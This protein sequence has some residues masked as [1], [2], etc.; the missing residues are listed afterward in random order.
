MNNSNPDGLLI[1]TS[2]ASSGINSTQVSFDSRSTPRPPSSSS[3]SGGVLASGYY[4]NQATNSFNNLMH[5]SGYISGSTAFYNQQHEYNEFNSIAQSANL[6]SKSGS[7]ASGQPGEA[8]Q[9]EKRDPSCLGSNQRGPGV[10]LKGKKVRKPRTIYSSMQLQVLNKRFQR[11]QYLALPERAELAASLGLTQTQVKIWFQNKRS[12]FKKNVKNSDGSGDGDDCSDDSFDETTDAET[13]GKHEDFYPGTEDKDKQILSDV[14]NSHVLHGSNSLHQ[15]DTGSAKTTTKRKNSRSND[16]DAKKL[17]DG[18]SKK[19][20]SGNDEIKGQ[21]IKVEHKGITENRFSNVYSK[22]LN[23]NSDEDIDSD[24][25]LSYS[26]NSNKSRTESPAQYSL[27]TIATATDGSNL[28]VANYQANSQLNPNSKLTVQSGYTHHSSS[29]PSSSSSSSSTSS[30]NSY[31]SNNKQHNTSIEANDEA[32]LR[33]LVNS[34]ANNKPLNQFSHHQHQQ[35]SNYQ[36]NPALA[37]NNY[38]LS[39]YNIGNHQGLNGSYQNQ[40]FN[41]LG[42]AYNQHYNHVQTGQYDASVGSMPANGLANSEAQAWMINSVQ[43][44]S[45]HHTAYSASMNST[46]AAFSNPLHNPLNTHHQMIINGMQ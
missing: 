32:I 5:N 36:F 3:S 45:Q 35:Q 13:G 29:L 24:N 10:K 16:C 2:A 43:G 27:N 42:L 14:G 46:S 39:N 30:I 8:S 31:T 22:I 18:G 20:K 11:T 40:S 44:A 12:K 4:N 26:T 19:F 9:H 41:N 28:P 25:S 17:S 21:K 6:L 38:Q 1:A 33:S 7:Y 23:S 34:A 37:P 15:V